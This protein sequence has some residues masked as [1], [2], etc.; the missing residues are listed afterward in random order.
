MMGT[1]GNVDIAQR[2]D[3]GTFICLKAVYF[4][5]ENA[6]IAGIVKSKFWL[7][8]IA[9]GSLYGTLELCLSELVIRLLA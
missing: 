5:G 3:F 7:L 9:Y 8:Y 6:F 4:E 2:S 1:Y